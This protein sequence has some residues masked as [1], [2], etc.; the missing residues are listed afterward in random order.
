MGFKMTGMRGRTDKALMRRALL[1]MVLA[2]V[3]VACGTGGQADSTPAV[4]PIDT[5]ESGELPEPFSGGEAPPVP[6]TNPSPSSSTTV[7][8]VGPI[9]G[10]ISDRVL[11]TRVLIIGDSILASTAPRHGGLMCDVLTSFGWDV[12]IDAE[13]GRRIEFADIVLDERLRPDDDVDWDVVAVFLGNN[14]DGDVESFERELEA[15]LERVAPRPVILYT[16]TET[17][18][19]RAVLNDFISERPQFHRDVVLIDWAGITAWEPDLLLADDGLHLTE[20]GRTRLVLFTAAELGD[21]PGGDEGDCLPPMFDD[22]TA[23][24]E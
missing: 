22:D 14:F 12:E 20:E 6:P 5:V 8:V 19:A 15:V 16:L 9:E 1:A 10:P 13:S 24:D 4:G 7:P 18:M 2:I 17:D 23:I 21:A 11:G 3:A